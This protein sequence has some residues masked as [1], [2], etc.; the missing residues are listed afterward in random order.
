MVLRK[1]DSS[2]DYRYF[3]EP[4]VLPVYISDAEIDEIRQKMP[5][6]AGE[7]F[8]LYV[9]DYSLSESDAK[10][11]ISDISLSSFFDEVVKTFPNYKLTANVILG[12]LLRLLNRLGK[13]IEE[14]LLSIEDFS[15]LLKMQAS[16]VITKNSVFDIL[17][18]MVLSHKK[19]MEIAKEKGYIIEDDIEKISDVCDMILSENEENV[20][21]YKGG[22]TKLFGYFMGEAIK[23][24]GKG[25]NPQTVKEILVRKLQ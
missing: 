8:K 24:L 22:N 4:D 9:S 12:D 1:K 6:S 18:K 25:V 17:E 5:M 3:P 21:L 16:K 15:E 10:L 2:D 13:G 20:G 11:L 7:K 14:I 19:P 23:V